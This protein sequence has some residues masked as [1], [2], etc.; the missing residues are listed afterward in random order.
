MSAVDHARDPLDDVRETVDAQAAEWATRP[1]FSPFGPRDPE[2]HR[3]SE[4]CALLLR[5]LIET[6]ECARWEPHHFVDYVE[7]PWH[8]QA[9]WDE[10]WADGGAS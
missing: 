4:N 3:N 10:M 2:W 5:W 6:G 1:P 7:K 8:W 9:E